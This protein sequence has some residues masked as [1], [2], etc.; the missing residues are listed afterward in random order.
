MTLLSLKPRQ[1]GINAH[2][3]LTF[4][5]PPAFDGNYFDGNVALER[6]DTPGM[7]RQYRRETPDGQWRQVGQI[8]TQQ[9]SEW[10]HVPAHPDSSD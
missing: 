2:Y 3:V 1:P 7:M 4:D 8:T 10:Y 6:A 5:A 9:A